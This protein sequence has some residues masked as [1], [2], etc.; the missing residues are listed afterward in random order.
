M[1]GNDVL[2]HTLS[3][4]ITV[5]PRNHADI[6]SVDPELTRACIATDVVSL[7]GGLFPFN[8]PAS[9]TAVSFATDVI[10]A[11]L[12]TAQPLD[13]ET[14]QSLLRASRLARR[15]PPDSLELLGA[16]CR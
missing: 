10:M 11:E 13:D 7:P 3:Q 8:G 6:Y 1:R 5:Q 4:P 2:I 16:P 14:R 9:S 12:H 15:T